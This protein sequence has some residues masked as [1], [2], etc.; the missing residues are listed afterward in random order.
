M[1]ILGIDPGTVTMGYGVIDTEDD[2]VALVD[3]GALVAKA[4]SPIGE[5]LSLLYNGLMEVIAR[6]QPEAVA[7]E[8]P[9]LAKNVKAALAIARPQPVASLAHANWGIPPYE[10]P[11]TTLKPRVAT[12]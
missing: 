9:F 12:S 3:C 11:P 7:V 2:E 10:Y 4:S 6:C 8:Q 1:R 5:R